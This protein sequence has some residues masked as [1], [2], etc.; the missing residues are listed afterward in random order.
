MADKLHVLMQ[1]EISG[2]HNQD[3][4]AGFVVGE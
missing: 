4:W 2:R 3:K 1:F